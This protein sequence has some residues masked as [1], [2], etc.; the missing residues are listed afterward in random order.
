M[1]GLGA[2]VSAAGGF[3]GK[4]PR[5][6][7]IALAVAVA[8]LAGFLWHQLAAHKAIDAAEK[9][10]EER[11]YANVEKQARE[12]ERKANAL[13]AKITAEMRKRNDEENRRI[14]AAADDLRLHGPG[15]ARCADPA[16]LSAGAGRHDA[17]GR[18]S[19]APGP[20][21]PSDER[22]A[23]PWGWLV[24]RAEQHDLNRAEALAWREWHRRFTA[25]WAKWKAEAE[26]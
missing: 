13:N 24:G 3:F 8:L 22:A 25:E 14:A 15:A 6:A 9:R 17:P 1:I 19:D 4:M 2:A 20:P 23:V 18:G 11:A 21:V 7:W 5:W 12:L 10:G 16:F 26:R